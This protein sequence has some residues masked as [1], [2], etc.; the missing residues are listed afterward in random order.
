MT[1]AAAGMSGFELIAKSLNAACI[2]AAAAGRAV[3][4]L[5]IDTIKDVPW[6]E[7]SD[8]AAHIVA[9]SHRPISARCCTR[10]LTDGGFTLA[11][12][13]LNGVVIAWQG[14]ALQAL[15]LDDALARPMRPWARALGHACSLDLFIWLLLAVPGGPETAAHI[16]AI[17]AAT[18]AVLAASHPNIPCCRTHTSRNAVKSTP[19]PSLPRRHPA[20][21]C[22]ARRRASTAERPIEM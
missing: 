21:I 17:V 10:C 16:E 22:S 14:L 5:A 1:C 12:M 8:D 2:A 3:A 11:L 4:V 19:R 15:D 9:E 7:I 13:L 18:L 6:G 20:T